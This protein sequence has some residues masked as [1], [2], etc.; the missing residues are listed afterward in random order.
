MVVFL[1]DRTYQLLLLLRLAPSNVVSLERTQV[2]LDSHCFSSKQIFSA[3]YIITVRLST[4]QMHLTSIALF[5]SLALLKHVCGVDC[6]VYIICVNFATFFNSAAS[7]NPFPSLV[8]NW[9]DFQ[10]LRGEE[11][12]HLS[13]ILKASLSSAELSWCSAWNRPL[14]MELASF[15]LI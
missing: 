15:C 2:S 6:T 3:V 1:L 9:S 4:E 12:G 8:S 11:R 5:E 13:N 10:N 7:M 14:S